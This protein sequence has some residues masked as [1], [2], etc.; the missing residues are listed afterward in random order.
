VVAH[1]LGSVLAYEALCANPG[2]PVTDLVTVGS[3]LGLR[4]VIFD[5]LTPPPVDEVG[6]WPGSVARWTNIADPGDIIALPACLADRFGRRVR[7]E[8]I[9]NGMRMHDLLRYLTARKTG[10]AITNG[11]R[12]AGTIESHTH[13]DTDASRVAVE[14]VPL[15]TTAPPDRGLEADTR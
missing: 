15:D 1:S 10:T 9:T 11:L 2:W 4:K 5:R 3:P 7:D 6:A 14:D 8:S 13:T 12:P